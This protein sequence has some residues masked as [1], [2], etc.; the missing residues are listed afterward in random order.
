[1]VTRC[2]PV[3]SSVSKAIRLIASCLDIRLPHQSV[4]HSITDRGWFQICHHRSDFFCITKLSSDPGNGRAPMGK[5][6]NRIRSDWF[7][8]FRRIPLLFR[9]LDSSKRDY[10]TIVDSRVAEKKG[11]KKRKK[12]RKSGGEWEFASHGWLVS[13]EMENPT[14]LVASPRWYY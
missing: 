7:F 8:A 1:M 4:L 13:R 11:K 10:D 6:I 2:S 5:V 3:F 14:T 9:N 12:K